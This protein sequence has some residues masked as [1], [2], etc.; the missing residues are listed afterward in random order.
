MQKQIN[1][2]YFLIR[3]IKVLIPAEASVTRGHSAA[4]CC[5]MQLLSALCSPAYVTLHYLKPLDPRLSSFHKLPNSLIQSIYY[6]ALKP[7]KNT[8]W[9]NEKTDWE[10]AH[11]NKDWLVSLKIN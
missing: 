2:H 3:F 6:S 11:G 9:F 10:I 8:S 7:P 4:G 5:E 1:I